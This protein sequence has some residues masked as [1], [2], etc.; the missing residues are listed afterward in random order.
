MQ[1]VSLGDLQA[2][3]ARGG[4]SPVRGDLLFVSGKDTFDVG[5]QTVTNS[6]WSHVAMF[7]DSELLIEAIDTA[8]VR[9]WTLNDY[10]QADN[11]LAVCSVAGLKADAA[12]DF[13]LSQL[14]S[15]YDFQEIAQ[16]LVRRLMGQSRGTAKSWI[17]S[18]LTAAAMHAGGMTVLGSVGGIT[19]E[20]V[21]LCKAVSLVARI[22]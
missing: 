22:R 11:M 7:Y 17:C 3:P 19:P 8:G 6:P 2:T 1:H 16:I 12:V 14:G 5:I 21:W 9:V 18:E 10:L 15:P 20:D 13:G 4:C